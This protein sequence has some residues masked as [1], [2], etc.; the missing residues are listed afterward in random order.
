MPHTIA[1]KTTG[2]ILFIFPL[3]VKY[4]ELPMLEI[5]ICILATFAA[6]QEWHY[7]RIREKIA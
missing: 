5:I 4:V 1:N 3:I 7:I 2:F 6:I